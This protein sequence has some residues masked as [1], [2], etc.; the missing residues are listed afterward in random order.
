MKNFTPFHAY[1]LG[2][3]KWNIWTTPPPHFIDAKMAR[4]CSF[5]PSSLLWGGGKGVNCSFL[6]CPSRCHVVGTWFFCVKKSKW[7]PPWHASH[8]CPRRLR[9][10]SLPEQRLLFQ[11]GQKMT[12]LKK[13]NQSSEIPS[14]PLKLETRLSTFN[15]DLV[16]IHF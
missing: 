10:P 14:V 12:I 1:K 5:V 11:N 13:I 16:L 6:F 15:L 8:P 3:N 2:Q 4:F 7:R 9:A